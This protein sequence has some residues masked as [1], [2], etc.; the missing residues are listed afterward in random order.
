MDSRILVPGLVQFPGDQSCP[1]WWGVVQNNLELLASAGIPGP[2]E[3]GAMAGRGE[4][5]MDDAQGFL[6]PEGAWWQALDQKSGGGGAPADSVGR[7][8]GGKM[9]P[10]GI[11]VLI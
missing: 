1:T 8:V 2:W 5:L 7:V 9:A 6:G 4:R 10:R 11:H 3:E